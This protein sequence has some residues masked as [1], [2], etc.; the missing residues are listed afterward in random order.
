MMILLSSVRS[1]QFRFGEGVLV[2]ELEEV[3]FVDAL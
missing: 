1:H 3:S 2:N